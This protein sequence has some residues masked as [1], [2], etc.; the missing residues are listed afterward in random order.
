MPV[1]SD[2]EIEA[3]RSELRE[4]KQKPSGRGAPHAIPPLVD[5]LG[6]QLCIGIL[7]H[8]YWMSKLVEK[9]GIGGHQE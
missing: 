3:A 1:P 5:R 6:D 2:E 4:M 8:D 9:V 7:I